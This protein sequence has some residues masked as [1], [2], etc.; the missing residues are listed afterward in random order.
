MK[1][2]IVSTGIAM[3]FLAV[4]T[5]AQ[6]ETTT[7]GLRAGVNFQNITGKA[8]D[9]SSLN[10]KLKTGFNIGANAEIPIAQ[11]FYVQ[12]GLLFS[13]KGAKGKSGS[14]LD[15]ISTSYLEVPVNLLYKPVLGD[16]KLLL[17]FGPYLGVGVAG[18][19]KYDNG[20]SSTIKFKGS[21]S[22]SDYQNNDGAYLKPTD[23]GANFLA[24]Y[25]LGNR[26]SLQLNAQLGLT[27]INPK[28][29]GVTSDPSSYKNTGFGLSLGYRFE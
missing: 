10:N 23:L 24:G 11:D 17:G 13:T 26:L 12:P 4:V 2:R 5:Q 7:F 22:Q 28:I 27:K 15:H 21:V 29:Q 20:N 3:L 16:G 18:K 25:E 6:S 8:I 1:R 19:V 14:G 9:G